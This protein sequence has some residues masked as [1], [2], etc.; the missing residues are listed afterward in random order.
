M[1]TFKELTEKRQVLIK[2][3]S[4]IVAAGKADTRKWNSEDKEKYKKIKDEIDSLEVER[5]AA[6][7]YETAEKDVAEWGNDPMASRSAGDD[8]QQAGKT[9]DNG[10]SLR[11][12]VTPLSQERALRS[13]ILG[14]DYATAEDI[15]ACRDAGLSFNA[16]RVEIPFTRG[17]AR[18]RTVAQA[19]RLVDDL[20]EKRALNTYS[21]TVGDGQGGGYTIPDELM[22]SIE[23]AMLAFGGMRQVSRVITTNSGANL[24]MPTVNDTGNEGIEVAEAATHPTQDPTIGQ[25]TYGAWK[26]SSKAV[27]VSVE[28]LQ[29]S[30][31][32]L[33]ELLGDLL[34]ERLGRIQNNRATAGTGTNQA[35]G[36]TAASGGTTASHTTAATLAN[37]VTYQDMVDLK[38][39][40]D[41]AYRSSP[42]CVF[43][44]N[45]AMLG[46]IKK[47]ADSQGRPLFL[48]E[49]LGGGY[50]VFDGHNIVINNHLTNTASAKGVLFGD[51][52][53]FIIREVAGM[54]FR[55][56]DE[57]YAL[58][59]QVGF[60]AYMRFDSGL[61][62]AGVAP[63]KHIVL[64][65]A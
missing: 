17:Y 20:R 65:A 54:E 14:P 24:P 26:Y 49:Q 51:F 28:L 55:R 45:D 56:L 42:S 25:K 18:P 58:S 37:G 63:I 61:L 34:G 60:V 10:G 3:A 30:N 7:D 4:D 33:G 31:E 27:V 5:Q 19:Q 48:P 15:R 43:M 47:W 12:P 23:R 44:M 32:P 2:Q 13:W 29:D 1:S 21:A 9:T 40:V 35:R 53:K 50:S 6:F 64:A 36:V 52:S 41:A 59:G 57:L 22:A 46:K 38:H 16:K 39:S 11:K 62:N 8:R